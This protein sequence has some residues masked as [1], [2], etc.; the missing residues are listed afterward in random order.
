MSGKNNKLNNKSKITSL[1]LSSLEVMSLVLSRSVIVI[2]GSLF[3]A[4]YLSTE[5]IRLIILDLLF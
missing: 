1:I 4:S 5:N 3:Q 2:S